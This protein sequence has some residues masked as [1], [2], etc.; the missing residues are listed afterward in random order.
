VVAERLR[1]PP[2]T[3][4]TLGRAVC[5]A[6]A[7]T[8]ARRLGIMDDAHQTADRNVAA[9]ALKPGVQTV[10]LLGRDIP[11]LPAGDGTLRAEDG[12]KAASAKSVLS[13]AVRNRA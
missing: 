6:S 2:D 13:A 8:K 9:A 7:R 12:G 4:L 1:Y 3:A 10:R 11:V 5:S